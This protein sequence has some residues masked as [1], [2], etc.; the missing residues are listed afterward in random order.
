MRNLPHSHS[1]KWH[2]NH[3][4]A[5]GDWGLSRAFVCSDSHVPLLVSVCTVLQSGELGGVN[6]VA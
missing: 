4:V 2:Q 5:T 6:S 1:A 3:K